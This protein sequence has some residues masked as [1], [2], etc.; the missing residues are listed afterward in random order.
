MKRWR[1][2]VGNGNAG[3]KLPAERCW[4]SAALACRKP[5]GYDTDD[6]HRPAIGCRDTHTGRGTL[7]RVVL[8][9]KSGSVVRIPRDL[10]SSA[11]AERPARVRLPVQLKRLVICEEA[12]AASPDRQKSSDLGI[13]KSQCL[14]AAPG[15]APG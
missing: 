11:A 9:K 7:A 8:N 3:W 13:A 15:R 5:R 10:R 6:P 14:A 12:A 4:V 1:F 2:L